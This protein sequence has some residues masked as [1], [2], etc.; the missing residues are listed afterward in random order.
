MIIDLII[1]ALNEERSLPLLLQ[2][3]DRTLIRE[4]VVVDN[5]STDETSSVSLG[6][7]AKVLFEPR[8]G[9]GFAC[10]AGIEY[11]RNKNSPPEF[12]VFMDADLADD[13]ADLGQLLLPLIHSGADLVIGSRLSG[14]AEPGSMTTPQRFG[15]WLSALL[16]KIFFGVRFT[17]LGPFRAIRL[18]RLLEMNM[19][20][21]T[22]GWTVE[23]QLKAAK[24]KMQCTE[25]PVHYRKRHA[26]VS[27]VS[28]TISGTILAGYRILL[29][30]F[31]HAVIR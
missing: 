7:G 30:V 24:M 2:Q 8:R 29:V 26:G 12:L 15:N 14:N 11:S 6:A 13:P 4:V 19:T 31:R 3:I 27:K 25:V 22:Y 1:P 20:E 16:I 10:M 5:G 9:Y 28:G 23:M 17:D 21:M 18:S